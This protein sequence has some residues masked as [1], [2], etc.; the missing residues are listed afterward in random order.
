MS[1]SI[2]KYGLP[3][4][5][6][7]S[8]SILHNCHVSQVSHLS[9]RLHRVGLAPC[10][11]FALSHLSFKTWKKF[12]RLVFP[13]QDSYL[14]ESLTTTGVSR[15]RLFPVAGHYRMA[16]VTNSNSCRSIPAFSSCLLHCEIT[17]ALV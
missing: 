17:I 13:V 16:T 10:L 9:M 4:A 11:R 6:N 14:S 5:T 12:S 1:H 7:R 3:E 2:L 15:Q 8:H